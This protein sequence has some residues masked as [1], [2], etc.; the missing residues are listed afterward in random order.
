M[1]GTMDAK[2]RKK[3]YRELAAEYP[4]IPS[5]K[6][7]AEAEAEWERNGGFGV[8]NHMVK[9]AADPTPKS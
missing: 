5:Y 8:F 4:D 9:P 7:L 3:T 1:L 6:M 2:P